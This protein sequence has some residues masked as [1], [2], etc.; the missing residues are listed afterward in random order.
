MSA[1]DKERTRVIFRKFADG[2]VIALFPRMLGNYLPD[3]FGSYQHIG[4][5]GT[6][7]DGVI[8]ATR[9]AS[10]AEYMPLARELRSIGYRL[11]IRKRMQF[12]DW[13]WRAAELER[14]RKLPALE[15]R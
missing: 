1:P 14:I 12:S 11:D 13:L 2:D 4:Q 7:Y 3:T 8:L 10:Q 6:A 5:H 15:K 9:P